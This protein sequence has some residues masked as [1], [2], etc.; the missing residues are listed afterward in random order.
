MEFRNNGWKSWACTAGCPEQF[1][2]LSLG[3]VKLLAIGCYNIDP[4]N[5][6]AGPTPVL[7]GMSKCTGQIGLG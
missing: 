6:L 2:V 3:A 7:V 4:N 1:A 5:L